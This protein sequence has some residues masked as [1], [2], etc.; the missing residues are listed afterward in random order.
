M[1]NSSRL[2]KNNYLVLGILG[3]ITLWLSL[4]GKHYWHEI[5]FMYAATQ[6]SM[7]EILSGVFNPHQVGGKIDEIGAGGFYLTKVMHLVLLKELFHCIPPHKGGFL[8]AS[9][10]SVILM[11]L[12]ALITYKIYNKLF[13]DTNKAFLSIC[14]FLLIPT[15]PYLAGKILSEV[16]ALFFIAL[17]I[18]TFSEGIVRKQSIYWFYVTISGVF[19][20]FTG[21]SRLDIILCFYGYLVASLICAERE[22]KGKVLLAGATVSIIFIIGEI[23]VNYILGKGIQYYSRYFLEFVNAGKKS[24]AMSIF[25]IMTFGGLVY[26]L[27]FLAMFTKPK[28]NVLLLVIWFLISAGIGIAITWNYMVEPRYL[29]SGILPMVGLASISLDHILGKISDTKLKILWVTIGIILVTLFN[30]V[31]VRL[32][33]YELNQSSITDAVNQIY[34]LDKT[35]IILI[36]WAYT[37]FHF[38]HVMFPGKNIINVH[39]GHRGNERNLDEVW[40]NRLK[41]WYGDNYLQT[42]ERFNGLFK[43][44]TIFYLSWRKYPPVE[45]ASRIANAIG[46]EQV[47]QYLDNLPLID[48]LTESWVW[49]SPAYRFEWVWNCG[50][51]EIYKVK[52]IKY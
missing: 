11:G 50:Q 18:L 3:L 20:L 17:C 48:H 46:F 51:Y 14:C 24:N 21:F 41:K 49:H 52:I 42:P 2:T 29:V 37:D 34:S 7:D 33:P 45:E 1:T 36:P 9:L 30:V 12:T 23:S 40:E 25:G 6:F 39:S 15:T 8:L 32:M 43:K 22:N 10:F 38:L 28:K 26:L 31:T 35:S 4:D 44:G 19:L 47:S 16:L 5:R 27:A 13:N